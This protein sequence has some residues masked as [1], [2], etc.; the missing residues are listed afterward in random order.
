M[1]LKAAPALLE[2]FQI[3]EPEFIQQPVDFDVQPDQAMETDGAEFEDNSPFGL[4][5]LMRETI[6]ILKPDCITR[7]AITLALRG[8]RKQIRD[9]DFVNKILNY[10]NTW[11]DEYQVIHLIEKSLWIQGHSDLVM[12]VTKNPTQIP[13][14]PPTKILNALNRANTLHPQSNIYYCV[15]LFGDD[16]TEDGLPIPVTAAEVR[17]ESARRIRAAQ[18]HAL[19]W[20]WAY[21]AALSVIRFPARCFHY[22][23]LVG[24]VC[25]HMGKAVADYNR[26]VRADAKRRARAEI[27]R[28]ME[29]YRF[30]CPLT[31]MPEHTTMLGRGLDRGAMI[32]EYQA[33]LAAYLAPLIGAGAA[34]MIVAAY[35]PLMFVPITIV[36]MDP[37]LFVELPEEPGKLRHLGHWYWQTQPE[38]HKKLHLHV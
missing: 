4:Q 33:S 38:G 12:T 5:G 1:S 22:A 31:Q 29:Q 8:T 26:R 35:A 25:Y 14:N 27:V 11:V 24:G 32:L 36:T 13:D 15:P 3:L 37:F 23:R 17:A 18:Q 21:R 34:P 20:G 28:Q 16:K 7:L 10:D 2:E 6:R 19:M 30:G 9:M